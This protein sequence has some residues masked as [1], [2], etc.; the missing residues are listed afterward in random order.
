[1]TS[2]SALLR[3]SRLPVLLALSLVA[4]VFAAPAPVAAAETMTVSGAESAMVAALNADRK[5]V[6]LIALQVDTRLMAIARA[7]SV[8]M[9]TKN[10]FSHTQPDGRNAFD[11]ISAAKI[12]WYSAGEIIAWNN[13]PTL[14]TSVQAANSQW[15]NSPGHKKLIVSTS[16]NYVGVGLAVDAASGKKYW[17]AVFIKGPDRTGARATT[18]A[19]SVTSGSTASTKKVTVSWSGADVPLQVLTS[20]FHSYKVQRRVDG[21]AWTTV[22]SST[23]TRSMTL[24]L[25]LNHTYQFRVAA[26]DKAGNWGSWST[27]Q[28]K[29]A[30]PTGSAVVR[31]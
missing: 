5:A 28:A 17:T 24:Q 31:R 10:Y 6:G 15:L 19:P 25:T 20:G 29:L 21:G 8:D 26:R 9:A 16:F 7:R 14:E 13:Y 23:T 27:V 4:A 11:L 12:T 22:W 3:R 1:M 30:A 18:A 2:T